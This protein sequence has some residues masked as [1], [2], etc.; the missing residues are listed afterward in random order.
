MQLRHC[1]I[2]YFFFLRFLMLPYRDPYYISL[3]NYTCNGSFGVYCCNCTV[4]VLMLLQVV[5]VE[6]GDRA[7]VYCTRLYRIHLY[8]P[9]TQDTWWAD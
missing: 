8:R 7:H 6:H 4:P 5:L 1:A 3:Q 2:F 9:V